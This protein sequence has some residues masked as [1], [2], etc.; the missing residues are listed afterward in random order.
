[1][2]YKMNNTNHKI[3]LFIILWFVLV[4]LL[5]APPFVIDLFANA[6]YYIPGM[7]LLLLPGFFILLALIEVLLSQKWVIT[8]L[9]KHSGFKG[10]AWAFIL[11]SF[12]P[13]PVYLSF[14]IA[15]IL[16]KKGVSKFNVMLFISAWACFN[17]TE[18]IFEINFL[19]WKFFLLRFIITLPM[20]I[21]ISF[22]ME[23]WG[24]PK[25]FSE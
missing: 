22:A 25:R 14:P 21:I 24:D 7:V 17:I 11:G 23:K 18:E 4:I 13:G 5:F 16:L 20:I 12:L 3:I 8:H 19:G 1:M 10:A 9:G 6:D 2:H 15:A